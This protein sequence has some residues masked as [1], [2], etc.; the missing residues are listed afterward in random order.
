MKKSKFDIRR[1]VEVEDYGK[2]TATAS[3]LNSISIALR[4]AAIFNRRQRCE[5]TANLRERQSKQI[6]D[7]LAK[8]GFYKD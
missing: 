4:E 8:T 5:A 3:A 7:A 6:Y 2:I 1:T